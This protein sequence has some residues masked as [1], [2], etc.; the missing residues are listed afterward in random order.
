M[1]DT[2]KLQ[3]EAAANIETSQGDYY[4]DTIASAEY[5]ASAVSQVNDS[6]IL[7]RDEPSDSFVPGQMNPKN[8][9]DTTEDEPL[10]ATIAR[11]A[12]LIPKYVAW[13]KNIELSYDKYTTDSAITLITKYLDATTSGTFPNRIEEKALI[14]D[15]FY[16][17]NR[18]IEF[19]FGVLRKK[20][21]SDPSQTVIEQPAAVSQ[22]VIQVSTNQM[23][24]LELVAELNTVTKELCAIHQNEGELQKSMEALRTERDGLIRN[25]SSLE[26]AL[27]KSNSDHDEFVTSNH[28][29][30]SSIVSPED[31][32]LTASN[33]K[34]QEELNTL[35]L[36]YA[37]YQPTDG[38]SIETYESIKTQ[39]DELRSTNAALTASNSKLQEE[40]KALEVECAKFK[41]TD[42]GSVETYESIKKQ[43]C[44][45]SLNYEGMEK[46]NNELQ[47]RV[48]STDKLNEQIES[49]T[50]SLKVIKAR[51]TDNLNEIT[52]MTGNFV[53]APL[54]DDNEDTRETLIAGM[55][56]VIKQF[57]RDANKAP[58]PPTESEVTKSKELNQ[59]FE[60]LQNTDF[61]K[62]VLEDWQFPVLFDII[63]K[64]HE[65]R[66][67]ALKEFTDLV[68]VNACYDDK[69]MT[70]MVKAHSE[71]NTWAESSAIS[72]PSAKIVGKIK[73][74]L[75]SENTRI[76]SNMKITDG[77]SHV[78][79]T[80]SAEL[81]NAIPSLMKSMSPTQP[82]LQKQK[83]QQEKKPRKKATKEP[84]QYLLDPAKRSEEEKKVVSAYVKDLK[85]RKDKIIVTTPAKTKY[86]L[87]GN[88]SF[89]GGSIHN[90]VSGNSSELEEGNATES[91]DDV[92]TKDSS[93]HAR[94]D[95]DSN[96]EVKNGKNFKRVRTV[97]ASDS[98]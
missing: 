98:E 61:E 89:D 4:G 57:I 55:V 18:L 82:G 23:K 70:K 59:F 46:S 69:T 16:Y 21:V 40:F 31:D 49:V 65:L 8:P 79:D 62:I 17:G 71:V 6:P 32:A 85:M 30:Q 66:Q 75:A 96:D 68:H 45:V 84:P 29:L 41:P 76:E 47:V 50:S 36:A 51:E 94:A 39:L 27:K 2:A 58:L 78:I 93:K 38:A 97:E 74:L 10:D 53:A 44:D 87:L 22:A 95:E 42:G 1:G 56:G 73:L 92:V 80:F 15:S 52:Q 12:G 91:D 25:N 33:A 7:G 72:V 34:L 26:D 81:V 83:K 13:N 60:N 86:D 64:D 28:A 3:L 54:E 77:I 24:Y 35:Q 19:L 43:L 14:R 9:F 5:A 37:K 11:I 20:A 63:E 48:E 67:N 90:S 88:E